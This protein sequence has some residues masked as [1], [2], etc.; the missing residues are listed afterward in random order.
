MATSD[1][2]NPGLVNVANQSD[3]L[4][5]VDQ[6]VTISP[7]NSAG[8]ATP[9]V[10]GGTIGAVNNKTVTNPGTTNVA[11]ETFGTGLPRNV[12]VS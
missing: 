8:S 12:N 4:L 10:A 2:T 11:N 3:G 1:V 6:P 9:A 5:S 7:S